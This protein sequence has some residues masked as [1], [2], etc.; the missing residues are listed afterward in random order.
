[1]TALAAG[2]I[3]FVGSLSM[4]VG[5]ELAPS[6]APSTPKHAVHA[7]TPDVA[8]AVASAV[9][10]PPESAAR[11]APDGE[12]AERPLDGESAVRQPD[13]AGRQPYL[14]RVLEH[15]PG[16]AGDAADDAGPHA[17]AQP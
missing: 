5:I 12:Q 4:A 14:T 10:P 13:P 15:I 16:D 8:E 9:A 11:T 3:T 17:P 7:I 2:A 1:M 6:G